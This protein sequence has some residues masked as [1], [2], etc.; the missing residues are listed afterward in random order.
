M[1]DSLRIRREG[2]LIYADVLALDGAIDALMSRRAIGN[3]GC[4]MAVILHVAEKAAALLDPLRQALEQ[5]G[6]LVAASCWNG[7][8]A[9]RMLAPEGAT[10]RRDLIAALAVLRGGRPLPRVWSC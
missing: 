9:V 5:A 7:I 1:R 6:G 2:K 8:L 3:G 4:A 10:L